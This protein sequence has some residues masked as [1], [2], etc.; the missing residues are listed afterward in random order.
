MCFP[1]IV[2]YRV[3][4]ERLVVGSNDVG[5]GHCRI[6]WTCDGA[7]YHHMWP[8]EALSLYP[9]Q[10]RCPN[11]TW[12]FAVQIQ[13][14]FYTILRKC[15][16]VQMTSDWVTVGTDGFVLIRSFTTWG[17]RG[18]RTL[19]QVRKESQTRAVN[20]F[21]TC[22][23]YFCFHRLYFVRLFRSEERRVGKECRL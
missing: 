5:L 13:H 14:F 9:G 22:C 19:V 21:L 12:L 7:E 8:T 16:E 23:Q 15:L 6:R 1:E 10:E 17:P 11:T 18:P 4:F 2:F 20:T 3:Y